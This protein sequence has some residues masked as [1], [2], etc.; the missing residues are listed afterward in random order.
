MFA[1]LVLPLAAIWSAVAHESHVD[2]IPRPTLKHM[3]AAE[4]LFCGLKIVISPGNNA[5]I[6][7]I[8]EKKLDTLHSQNTILYTL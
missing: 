8:G 5:I 1:F 7:G 4:Q 6:R 2:T 3:L